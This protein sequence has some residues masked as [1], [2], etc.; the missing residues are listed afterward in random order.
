MVVTR[1]RSGPP[2]GYPTTPPTRSRTTPPVT[3]AAATM[4]ASWHPRQWPTRRRS[5]RI[6][7]DDRRGRRHGV[8]A[9]DWAYYAEKVRKRALR[10]STGRG[11]CGRTSSWSG[12]AASTGLLRRGQALRPHL[13]RAARPRGYHPEVAHVR[14]AQRATAPA[15]PLPRRLLHPARQAWRRVDEQP[16]ATRP[17]SS[18]AARSS[19]TTSTSTGPRLA[20]RRC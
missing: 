1:A 15:G 9:W 6:C 19:S 7:E 8:G 3:Q 16:G 10:S 11:T 4:L 12:S 18:D 20:S 14:G 13:R 2:P 17:T 5:S